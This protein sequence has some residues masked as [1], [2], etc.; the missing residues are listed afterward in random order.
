MGF[1]LLA[2][3]IAVTAYDY[4]T[5]TP[6]PVEEVSY[7]K[8]LTLVAQDDISKV[9]LTK[10]TI[11]FTTKEDKEFTTIAPTNRLMT[12]TWLMCCKPKAWK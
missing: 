2:I 3:F 12:T 7:S 11:K 6:K 1:Y 8:F 4:L 5:I 9:V 10:N